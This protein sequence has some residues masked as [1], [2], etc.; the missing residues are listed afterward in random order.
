MTP[1][2]FN[3]VVRRF[4]QRTPFH[5]FTLEL[6]SGARLEVNH[7]EAMRVYRN[8]LIRVRSSSSVYSVFEV[9]EI[10]RFISATG[11]T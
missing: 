6:L 4:N 11:I 8:G 9:T 3:R 7:P 1:A 2:N 5:P 10:V